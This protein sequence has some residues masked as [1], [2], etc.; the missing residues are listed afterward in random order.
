MLQEDRGSALS[1]EFLLSGTDN[2][3]LGEVVLDHQYHVISGGVRE[4]ANQVPQD[5]LPWLGRYRE[6]VERSQFPALTG[7]RSLTYVAGC[8][9]F[10]GVLLKGGPVPIL[11]DCHLGFSD[12]GMYSC[13]RRVMEFQNFLSENPRNPNFVHDLEKP[14]GIH[15]QS[16]RQGLSFLGIT[17]LV[18]EGY[19]LGG[20]EM[21]FWKQGGQGPGLCFS[22][23]QLSG[24]CI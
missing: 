2:D 8:D 13:P 3:R 7:F 14:F 5:N 4:G 12:S 24:K 9:I 16:C 17:D 23:I 1:S 22:I 10:A 21:L 6:G 19:S 15:L 20:V 18:Q 11:R